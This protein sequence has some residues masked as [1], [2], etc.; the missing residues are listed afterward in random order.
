MDKAGECPHDEA[1]F[2]VVGGGAIDLGA[3]LVAGGRVW[4]GGNA[5]QAFAECA[6]GVIHSAS[7]I[8]GLRGCGAVRREC[9]GAASRLRHRWWT[10]IPQS[11]DERAWPGT[12]ASWCKENRGW[13]RIP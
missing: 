7:L 3:G 12:R 9:H 11:R 13:L 10:T 8:R 6:E 5:Q 2:V 1:V 4:I